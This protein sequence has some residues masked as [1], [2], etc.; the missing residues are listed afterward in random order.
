MNKIFALTTRVSFICSVHANGHRGKYI[1]AALDLSIT[2]KMLTFKDGVSEFGPATG[3]TANG[4]CVE[5]VLWT[6]TFNWKTPGSKRAL[7]SIS[8]SHQW[9]SLDLWAQLEI[10]LGHKLFTY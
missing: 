2:I 8:V 9:K 5:G 4:P 10:A 7:I 6:L 3:W 1:P